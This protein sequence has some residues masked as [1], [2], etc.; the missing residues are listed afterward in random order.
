MDR[1]HASPP[2][3]RLFEL[4]RQW[5]SRIAGV[6]PAAPSGPLS[7]NRPGDNGPPQ[8]AAGRAPESG[9]PLAFCTLE[10]VP[11]I[12]PGIDHEMVPRRDATTLHFP[13]VHNNAYAHRRDRPSSAHRRAGGPR[14][15]H[16]GWW[17]RYPPRPS[18]SRAVDH[19]RWIVLGNHC[20]SAPT[21]VLFSAR[22]GATELPGRTAGHLGTRLSEDPVRGS[23]RSTPPAASRGTLAC[24]SPRLAPLVR[25]A[26]LRAL[27]PMGH[28]PVLALHLRTCTN[29]P[30]IC[31]PHLTVSRETLR[32]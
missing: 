19:Q 14:P 25:A 2:R 6:V 4:Y 26:P 24:A 29:I 27:R 22:V 3:G 5:S 12:D 15:R 28:G 18:H 21:C 11:V 20:V 9:L 1:S 23:R 31:A 32:R 13:A 8:V 16:V 10:L 7:R 30:A 17:G